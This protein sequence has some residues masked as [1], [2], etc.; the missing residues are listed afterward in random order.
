MVCAAVLV[1]AHMFL[2]RLIVFQ[3]LVFCLGASYRVRRTVH[4]VPMVRSSS[5]EGPYHDY[6]SII[7]ASVRPLDVFHLR[8]TSFIELHAEAHD[9]QAAGLLS[10]FVLSVSSC[11]DV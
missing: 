10:C 11:S 8:A 9:L 6:L 1:A 4:Q 5:Q 7:F 2:Y 3:D